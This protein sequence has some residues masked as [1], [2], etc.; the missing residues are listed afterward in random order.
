MTAVRD[1]A[2]DRKRRL[3]M[4]LPPLSGLLRSTGCSVV[5]AWRG[6]ASDLLGSAMQHRSAPWPP[7]NTFTT[8]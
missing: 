6:A 4:V 2:D 1:I 7:S 3:G 8:T 5:G